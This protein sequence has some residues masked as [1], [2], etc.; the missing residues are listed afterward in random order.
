VGDMAGVS[1]SEYSVEHSG[2]AEQSNMPTVQRCEWSASDI[3][4]FWEEH[5][6][7]LTVRRRLE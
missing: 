3:A 4:E 5:T 6:A 2:G 1:L 7:R